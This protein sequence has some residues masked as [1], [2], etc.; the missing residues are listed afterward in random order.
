MTNTKLVRLN[1]MKKI[2]LTLV[3]IIFINQQVFAVTLSEALSQAYKNN[4]E[5]NAERENI[6]VSKE[7]L[8]ISKSEFLPTLSISGS[9]SQEN[10]TKL[11]N[12][13]GADI[14]ATD[15]DP[16]TQ[17][18]KIEQN[19]YQGFGGVA[20]REKSKI[21]LDIAKAKLQ[22]KEQEIILKAIEAYSG[23]ILANEKLK[24]NESNLS[25]LE[26]QVE[27]DQVRL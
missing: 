7:D 16:L 10:T 9:K 17:T 27:T 2:F 4:P 21:N 22:K 13:S 19:L 18:F 6:K 11:T 3:F 23:L 25:L 12:Q 14:S 5:L 20:K 1:N 24:I 15:T 8:K 26:R